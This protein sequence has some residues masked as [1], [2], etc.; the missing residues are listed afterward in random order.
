[1]STTRAILP[2]ALLILVL[3][4]GQALGQNGAKDIA[5]LRESKEKELTKLRSEIASYEKKLSES[6]KKEKSTLDH[7]D[8]P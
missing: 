4:C 8:D 6:E 5:S 1:M 2:L 7:I 3:P